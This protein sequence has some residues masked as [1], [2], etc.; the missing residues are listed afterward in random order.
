MGVVDEAAGWAGVVFL[1]P[2]VE[3]LD[4]AGY[5]HGF[6]HGADAGDAAGEVNLFWGVEG[7]RGRGR[8]VEWFAGFGE[9]YGGRGGRL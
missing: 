5:G 7:G 3:G 6:A 2:W 9:R 1:E 8:V 4:G